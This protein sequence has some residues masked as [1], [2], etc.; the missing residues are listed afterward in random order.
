V[1]IGSGVSNEVSFD[2]GPCQI[3]LNFDSGEYCTGSAWNLNVIS[4]FGGAMMHLSGTANGE[5]WEITSW[6]RT[7]PDGSFSQTGTFVPGSEGAHTMRVRIGAAHS[8]IFSFRVS[9]CGP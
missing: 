1:E 4:N 5:P 9:R 6:G 2:I 7:G 8:N 3:Q